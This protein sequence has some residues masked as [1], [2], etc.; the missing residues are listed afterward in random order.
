MG[1]AFQMQLKL[2]ASKTLLYIAVNLYNGVCLFLIL[3]SWFKYDL[4]ISVGFYE[5]LHLTVK[6]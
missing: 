6:L 4:S 1:V 3:S 2:L 5:K